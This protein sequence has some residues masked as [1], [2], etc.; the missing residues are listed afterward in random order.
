MLITVHILY[1]HGSHLSETI[2]KIVG[3]AN[4][5]QKTVNYEGNC[6]LYP[7]VEETITE[8]LIRET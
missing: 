1:A 2:V 3:K 4:D 5:E 8:Y 6:E 7:M